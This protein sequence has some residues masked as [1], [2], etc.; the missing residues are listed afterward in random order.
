MSLTAKFVASVVALYAALLAT[1]LAVGLIVT[2]RA[3][4]EELS[5]MRHIVALRAPALML[6]TIVLLVLCIVI[7]NW[8]F[9]RYV[10]AVRRLVEQT[11]VIHTANA[12][13]RLGLED[14]RWLGELPGALNGLADAYGELRRDSEARAIEA[15]ARLEAG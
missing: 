9:K 14:A 11:R 8:F 5:A 10:F 4:D 2:Y 7:V 15:R 12:D 3:T 1:P 6:V 13:L